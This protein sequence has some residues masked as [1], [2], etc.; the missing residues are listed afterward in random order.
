MK[1]DIIQK[2][3]LCDHHQKQLTVLVATRDSDNELGINAK[4]L[5][6]L[7]RSAEDCTDCKWNTTFPT[8]EDLLPPISVPS[9]TEG[10]GEGK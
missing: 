1:Y 8:L 4:A 3:H 10:R 6:E 9:S 5:C 7:L 2:V